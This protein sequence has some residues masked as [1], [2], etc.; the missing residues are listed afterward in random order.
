MIGR[1]KE[2]KGQ[3]IGECTVCTKVFSALYCCVA[4]VVYTE[5]DVTVMFL[6]LC[7]LA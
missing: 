7:A 1:G 5:D 6:V 3:V 4:Q 2:S